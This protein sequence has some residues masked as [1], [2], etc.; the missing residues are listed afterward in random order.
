MLAPLEHCQK[1]RWQAQCIEMHADPLCLTGAVRHW[2]TSAALSAC[3]IN[4]V[5][6]KLRTCR[7]SYLALNSQSA[8]ITE[9]NCCIDCLETEKERLGWR[10]L[11]E[12]GGLLSEFR[13]WNSS[14]TWAV[15]T[16]LGVHERIFWHSCFFRNINFLKYSVFKTSAGVGLHDHQRV[17]RRGADKSLA[18]PIS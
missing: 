15:F 12:V 4:D 8:H 7:L 16:S 10:G 3:H 11:F 5:S 14:R 1:Y 2:W 13:A 17:I 18:F 6:E 9:R